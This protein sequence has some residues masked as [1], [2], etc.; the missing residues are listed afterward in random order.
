MPL[1]REEITALA[2]FTAQEVLNGLD[3][4]AISYQE[5]Q[6]VQQGLHESMGEELT[7]S[8]WYRRRA[9]N[10]RLRQG[11]EETARLYEH[12]AEEEDQHY[13]EFNARLNQL[14]KSCE[15]LSH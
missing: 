10:A 8:S 11:D 14:T 4:Y 6:T 13:Q 7:A 12:V 3:R 5:P 15:I 1:S 9:I 2:R